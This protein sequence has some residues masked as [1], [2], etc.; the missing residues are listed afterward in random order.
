MFKELLPLWIKNLEK[1]GVQ[2]ALETTANP[3][4]I[5]FSLGRPDNNLLRLPELKDCYEEL[6]S[7]HNLQYSPPSYELKAHIAEF[8][9]EKQVVCTPKEILLTTGAQQA[10]T[11]LTKLFA[12]EGADILVD[13]LTYPGFIQVAQ[14]MHLNLIPS[15]LC[16]QSGLCMKELRQIL[17]K[18]TR[19]SLMYTMS[20][21]HNPL[22]TSLSKKQRIELTKLAEEYK[23]PIIEDD[24][25]GF[26]NYDPV[27]S[28]LKSYSKEGVFYIGSFSKILA[29]S[30]RTGWIIASEPIIEKLEILKEGLDI[31]TNSFSQKLITSCFEKDILIERILKLREAYKEKRDVIAYSLQKYIPEME[32]TI[33][34]SGFFI[35]GKLPSSI[36]TKRLFKFALEE[37]K[38]SFIPGNAFL[39]GERD[40]VQSCLR[41]SFAFCPIELIELGIKRLAIAIQ[42]YKWQN[43]EQYLRLA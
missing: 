16:F 35:W 6:F 37:E 9:K 14:A 12:N 29:P 25:Y 32:F 7:P 28:P 40:D 1:S 8:M 10:M 13:Q 5:S 43:E 24:A 27:D 11:L 31:N 3:D 18:N 17:E 42:S 4:I 22:G 39:V 2:K 38:V 20:E 34:K 30:M 21:G 41:L 15:P 19:P 23:V 36:N 26:L 33:P